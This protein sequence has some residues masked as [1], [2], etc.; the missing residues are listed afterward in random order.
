MNSRARGPHARISSRRS[1]DGR[2]GE[3]G[4]ILV[5]NGC[6]HTRIGSGSRRSICQPRLINR[7]VPPLRVTAGLGSVDRAR[8]PL[9]RRR[10]ADCPASSDL[11][12][13][14]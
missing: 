12:G 2:R 1:S 11:A 10:G 9:R 8:M 6:G 5:L 3:Q 4:Q 7:R 13:H 14:R